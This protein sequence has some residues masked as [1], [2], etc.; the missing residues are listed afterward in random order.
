LRF[1]DNRREKCSKISVSFRSPAWGLRFVPTRF[2]LNAKLTTD[3]RLTIGNAGLPQVVGRHFHIDTVAHADT[4][5]VFPHFARNVSQHF[6]SVGQ[7]DAEHRSWQHLRYRA[8]KFDWF[9]FCHTME[10]RLVSLRTESFQRRHRSHKGPK[11]GV[12]GVRN[13]ARF[14]AGPLD[15]LT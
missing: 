13:Q 11:N 12:G 7:R 3:S 1:F 9:F 4:D 2:H 15:V 6:M 8:L 10:L 14:S 5:K